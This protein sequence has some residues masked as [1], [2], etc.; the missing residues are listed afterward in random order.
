MAIACQYKNWSPGDR[1]GSSDVT[2]RIAKHR[3]AVNGYS[4][5]S[6]QLIEQAWVGLPAVAVIVRVVWTKDN[7]PKISTGVRNGPAHFFMYCF[8]RRQ[9]DQLTTD[10]G[11][12]G[13]YGNRIAAGRFSLGGSAYVLACNDG[14][15]HLHGGQRGFDKVEWH[16]EHV[17]SKRAQ[18]LILSYTSADGE[19]GYPGELSVIVTY[20]LG[21]SDELKIDYQADALFGQAACLDRL[22]RDTKNVLELLGRALAEDPDHAEARSLKK[23]LEGR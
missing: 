12:I 3:Y 8:K 5:L 22:G 15:N 6:R 1:F 16:I 14:K 23:V 9:I 7:P 19:E 2:L 17:P 13:R 20:T 11:L 21:S 10:A 4:V 18:S